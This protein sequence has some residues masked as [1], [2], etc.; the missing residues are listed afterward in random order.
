MADLPT[1]RGLPLSRT[2]PPASRPA[3]MAGI[4]HEEPPAAA[5]AGRRWGGGGGRSGKEASEEVAR[6]PRCGGEGGGGDAE[7]GGGGERR[8]LRRLSLPLSVRLESETL[9]P[10]FAPLPRSLSSAPTPAPALTPNSTARSQPGN[11]LPLL[12]VPTS[13]HKVDCK[14]SSPPLRAGRWLCGEGRCER[15]LISR[16]ERRRRRCC[17]RRGWQID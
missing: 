15:C 13:R 14:P 6:R 7:G 3:S 9:S 17:P 8:T 5:M 1:P 16:R 11:H 10:H 12:A 4:R 2:Q